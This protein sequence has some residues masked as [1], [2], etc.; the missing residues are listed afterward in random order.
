MFNIRMG[1]P[2]MEA[3]W[4]RLQN[5]HRNGANSKKDEELYVKWGNALKKLARDTGSII[6][7]ISVIGLFGIQTRS[8]VRFQFR[9]GGAGRL[10]T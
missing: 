4:Y 9:S 10:L 7:D 1:I 8:V 3:M 5:G 6:E 2:E